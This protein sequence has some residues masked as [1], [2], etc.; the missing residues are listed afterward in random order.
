MVKNKF[1]KLVGAFFGETVRL[2]LNGD[3]FG[4]H[5]QAKIL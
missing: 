2:N 3:L 5:L 1:Q 4:W